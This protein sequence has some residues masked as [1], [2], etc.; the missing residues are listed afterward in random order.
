MVSAIFSI[1]YAALA[2]KETYGDE[3][4]EIYPAMLKV[5]GTAESYVVGVR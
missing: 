1:I 3:L 2:T 5:N 4:F